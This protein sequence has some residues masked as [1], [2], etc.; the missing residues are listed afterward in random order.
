MLDRGDRNAL[1]EERFSVVPGL[2]QEWMI[3]VRRR[4]LV[5]LGLVS[6][7]LGAT[8]Y[9]YTLRPVY[10]GLAVVTIAEAMAANPLARMSTELTRLGAIL[11][12]QR[13]VIRSPEF[14]ARVV[15]TLDAAA[16][17]ELSFGPIGSWPDRMRSEWARLMGSEG[18]DMPVD[19]VAALRS[20]LRVTGEAKST[21]IEIRD[22]G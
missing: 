19:T 7:L 12:R 20:R 10:E 11:E 3:I 16:L 13:T 17:K 1:N 5:V 6:A 18:S 21:W 2:R 8:I 9:N 15:E 4:R 14:A 22:F